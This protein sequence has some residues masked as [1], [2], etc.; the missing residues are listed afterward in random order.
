MNKILSI[1]IFIFI[2][3]YSIASPLPDKPHV[4]V[5]GSAEIE[6]DADTINFS[7]L[8]DSSDGDLSSSRNDIE[9]RSRILIDT[10][11][12]LGINPDAISSTPLNITPV[13][14]FESGERITIGTRVSRQ[15]DIQV[16]DFTKYKD[17]MSALIAAN[18]SKTIHTTLSVSNGEALADEALVKAFA[19]AKNRATQIAAVQGMTLGKPFS[20]SEIPTR[21]EERYSLHPSRRIEGKAG[22]IM[23][24][25]DLQRPDSESFEPGKMVARAQVFV[26]YFLK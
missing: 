17:I 5:E 7:V 6:V 18:I 3:A 15:V 14:K 22:R 23:A 21:G 11:I 10:C 4:Y 26:V 8:L 19:D 24:M 2:P 13:T 20:I 9:N 12:N 16:N 25:A 1:F